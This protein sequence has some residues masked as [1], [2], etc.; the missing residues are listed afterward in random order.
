MSI[1]GPSFFSRSQGASLASISTLCKQG[2]AHEALQVLE[3]MSQQGIPISSDMLYSVMRTCSE[4]KCLAFFRRIQILL[5]SSGLNYVTFLKDNLI[6]HFAAC[7]SLQD[8]RSIFHHVI[9]P[10]IYTWNSFISA[11]TRCGEGEEALA[12]YD[13]MREQKYKPDK[14]TF[15]SIINAC[16]RIGSAIS[17]MKTHHEVIKG[18]L[19]SDI[20]ISNTLLSMYSK[21]WRPGE[22]LFIFDRMQ[23]PNVVTWSALIASCTSH[24][25][26]LQALEHFERMLNQGVSPN[27]L[28]FSSVMGACG[29]LRDLNNSYCIHGM[30][31]E[32]NLKMD[33][34][35]GSILVDMYSRCGSTR[36]ARQIFDGLENHDLVTWGAMMSGYTMHDEATSVLELFEEMEH[37]KVKPNRVILLSVIKACS[38]L[39]AIQE[40]KSVHGQVLE[41]FLES[42]LAVGGALIDM[43]VKCGSLKE[44]CKVFEGLRNPDGVIWGSLV[45]GYAAEGSCE[46]VWQCFKEMQQHG[47]RPGEAIFTNILNAC[48]HAGFLEDSCEYLRRMGEYGVAPTLEHLGCMVDL[49]A[50]AGKLEEA[51][52][53]LGTMPFCPDVIIWRSVLTC[54]KTHSRLDLGKRC[55]DEARMI[56]PGD[57]A[58]YTLM[59]DLYAGMNRWEDVDYVENLRLSAGA[60]KVPGMAWIESDRKVHCFIVS[61]GV[62]TFTSNETFAKCCRIA[63]LIRNNTGFVPQLDTVFS[64]MME[65]SET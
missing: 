61:N 20:S 30:F 29:V 43:Y 54:S 28:T 27:L 1:T 42:D 21:C 16:S 4:S 53:I 6:R 19:E 62:N 40:G 60:Q 11:C 48:S 47:V 25:N 2:R 3:L 52:A 64:V 22:A 65:K 63:R 8:A 57:A 5:D 56:D 55:F 46:S 7:G 17:A 23:S 31:V 9:R 14:V 26:G 15:L 41:S 24:N 49:F 13:K 37:E 35:L 59:S 12:V 34:V 36:D 58:L 32:A 10:T 50:R 44:A 39:K 51:E 38:S 18:G 45:S 33:E